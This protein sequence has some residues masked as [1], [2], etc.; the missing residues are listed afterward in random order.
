MPAEDFKRQDSQEKPSLGGGLMER[1]ILFGDS[2]GAKLAHFA[3]SRDPN[4]QV[5]AFTV[6]RAYLKDATFLGL[7]VVAFDEVQ[8]AFPP[9]QCKMF[10]A[11]YANGM[12][13]LR[14][15]RC[16]QAKEKGYSLISYVHP[17]AIVAQDLEMGENC[18]IS[19]GVVCRPF[20]KLEDDVLLM[21]GVFVGHDTVIMSHCFIGARAVIMGANVVE[22]FCFVGPNATVMDQHRIGSESFIGGGVVL[23]KDSKEK[24]V[25]R[26]PKP[27]LMPL[28]SDK[29]VKLAFRRRV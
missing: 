10:I 2:A 11:I 20:V 3:L 29:L 8:D 9:Q 17:Q 21:P 12:N 5:V 18:Y 7:P 25:Y 6:D 14:A 28:S 27:I 4:Y 23:Q 1:I 26:A 22:P 15:E 24:E 13:K 16:A 19:E